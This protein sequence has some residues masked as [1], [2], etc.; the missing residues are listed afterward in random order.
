MGRVSALRAKSYDFK[1]QWAP[2]VQPE[3]KDYKDL[4]AP[5]TNVPGI[6]VSGN[7]VPLAQL[8]PASTPT[9]H[10]ADPDSQQGENE[11]S[12]SIRVQAVA[13]YDGAD[14]HGEA[15]RVIA[16]TNDMNKPDKDLLPG[17]PIA[18]GT[19]VEGS[20]KLADIDGDGVR[21]IIQPDTAGR[22]HVFTL[23]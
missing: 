1:V 18:L 11:R 22:V 15:R 23:R 9:A 14:V 2:G 5:L 17:F 12:I 3:D 19:S 10:T 21:D 13:H 4:T 16:I 20:A 8:D 7:G 6:T